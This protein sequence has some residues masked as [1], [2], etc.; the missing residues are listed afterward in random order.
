MNRIATKQI[1][2]INTKENRQLLFKYLSKF[3]GS[4]KAKEL[5]LKHK[6]NLFEFNG[7]AYSLGKRSIE[8]FCVYFLQDTFTPK[9]DNQARKLAP[10]HYEIWNN[11]EKMF[12]SDSFDKLELVMPRGAAKTTV[13]DFA[14]SVWAHCYKLSIYTLVAGKTEQDS[15]EFIR[16]TRR[17]FEENPYI[18][19]TFGE[20]IDTRKYTVNKLELELSN[21]SK[22]Q[23]ISSTSSMRGKK[24]N[25]NRPSLIIA[26]DYQ[27]KSDVIT[28]EARDKKYDTWQQDSVYAGDK[29]VIRNGKKVKMATK[30]IVLGTILHRDCF[31]SRLLKDHSYIHILEKAILVDDVD[32]L[33]NTGFWE[34]FKKIYFNPKVEL[35]QEHG[36]EFYCNHEEE[37]K[38]PVLWEDKYDCLDL[39]LDYYSNP[40]AFKQ[41]MQNDASKI[42]EKAFH[43]ITSMPREE[44]EK[45]TFTN[46]I[47][48]CD[49]AVETK[50]NNDY[51]ALLVGSKSTNNFRWVRKGLIKRLAFDDYID[52]VIELLEEYEDINTIWIEKNTF[53]GADKREIEKSIQKDINLKSRRISIVNERQTKNKEAKIRAISGKIDSG[54][55]IFAEEDKDFID[56]ILAYEGE[57]F[58]LHDDAPDITAEFDRLIDELNIPR[59]IKSIPKEWLF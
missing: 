9:P 57:K 46:T 55:I 24:F 21:I 2:V 50:A 18:K 23:A 54:F 1:D 44:I 22:I 7:L 32:Q 10:I 58:T 11:L 4:N 45:E 37:M 8:F 41:E 12:I 25:G 43:Q 15:I 49:P 28:Q 19:H 17:A 40:Q 34:E 36:R 56:Q 39:A 14:L 35:A 26:D 29:A 52:K 53:N 13:C 33:F 42:G 16:E 47:L 5:M 51:T 6:D 3:Y 38:Y 30:F 31:I 48:C 20:L 27:S 59:D